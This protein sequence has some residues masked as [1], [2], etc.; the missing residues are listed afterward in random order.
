MNSVGLR[1]LR[2]E[3]RDELQAVIERRCRRGDDPWQFLPDLPSVDEQ[4]VLT[5]RSEAISLLEL[6]EQRARVYHPAAPPGAAV[7]FEYGILRRIALDIPELTAAVWA[8][9]DCV[10][11]RRLTE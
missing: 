3:A 8:L 6:A 9:L 11:P 1:T 4:V 5:L 10:P 2:S 7:A